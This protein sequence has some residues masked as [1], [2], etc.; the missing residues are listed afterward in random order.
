MIGILTDA[1]LRWFGRWALRA[2]GPVLLFVLLLRVVDYAE[3]REV[4]SSIQLP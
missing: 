3:L 1:R 2:T 4:V